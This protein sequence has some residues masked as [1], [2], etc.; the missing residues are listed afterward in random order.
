MPRTP[1]QRHDS[2]SRPWVYP[3]RCM[4]ASPPRAFLLVAGP[5]VSGLAYGLLLPPFEASW[6]A[7]VALVPLLVALSQVGPG[8]GALL[9]LLFAVTGTVAVAWWFPAMLERFFE[10]STPVAWLGLVGLAVLIDGWPYAL[11]GAAVAFAVR[12]GLAGAALLASGF[13]LA[14]WLRA[15]GPVPNPFAQLGISQS[16]TPFAQLADLGGSYAVGFVVCAVNAALAAF[17]AP[18]LQARHRRAAPTLVAG[19]FVASLVYG[20]LRLAQDFG[21]GE[22]ARV[23]LVQGAV[24]RELRWDR[25]A[26]DAHLDRYLDLTQRARA[27]SPDLVF[28]PEFAV[29]FYLQEPSPR[30]ARLL[31]D[32]RAA[33]SD[34]VLGGSR[35]ELAAGGTR[36][37]NTVFVVDAA[38]RLTPERYDKQQLIPFAEYGPFGD[39]LRAE[40]AVYEPGDASRLLPTK[41][42][43]LGA[44]ICGESLFPGIAR[45]MAQDGAEVLVNPSNDYWFGRPEAAAHQLQVAAFRSIENRRYMVRATSTGVSAVVD[46]HGRTL[47][48]SR[49]EGPEVLHAS[50]RRSSA[51]TVYQSLG[52]TP[53]A[54]GALLWLRVLARR[55]PH[56]KTGGE[57]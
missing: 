46:A 40:T 3:V 35:Y 20:Q 14:E 8:R 18:A 54:A 21:D 33:G 48:A 39:F 2:P 16:G 38:G 26:R 17:L 25:G 36:Y 41:E 22:P 31:R 5:V 57:R 23:A 47:V 49:G 28:W 30:R 50:V 56:E 10:L 19:L 37:Y 1:T 9:G 55:R 52:D 13:V 6:L 53:L 27:E 45:R 42:F 7:W 4:R 29:D 15:H 12:R 24:A 32:V 43:L 51:T 11:F 44:F 34:L